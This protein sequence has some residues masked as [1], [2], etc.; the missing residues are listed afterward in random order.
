MIHLFKPI[1]SG[2]PLYK[3]ILSKSN[4]FYQMQTDITTNVTIISYF[5]YSMTKVTTTTTATT[6]TIIFLGP[7]CFATRGQKSIWKR[8]GELS[9]R[10]K[11]G[12]FVIQCENQTILQRKHCYRAHSR[13]QLLFI[14]GLLSKKV[15]QTCFVRKDKTSDNPISHFLLTDSS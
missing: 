7:R 2:T 8:I 4:R 9:K 11:I 3:S 13:I 5:S 6:T 12:T 1:K 14:S 10:L 15:T